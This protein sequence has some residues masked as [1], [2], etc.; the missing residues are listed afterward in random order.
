MLGTES[1]LE[2]WEYPIY[3]MD[4]RLGSFL[5]QMPRYIRTLW[6]PCQDITLRDLMADREVG[7]MLSYRPSENVATWAGNGL[8][9]TFD[10]KTIAQA[11]AAGFTVDFSSSSIDS[12]RL[13]HSVKAEAGLSVKKGVLRRIFPVITLTIWARR[14]QLRS[15]G[16]LPSTSRWGI[17]IGRTRT[18]ITL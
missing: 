3:A 4:R 6:L 18:R 16:R 9:G 11:S 13:T 12:T 14:T 2:L 10:T 15:R 8:V 17:S 5:V 1:S 7:N